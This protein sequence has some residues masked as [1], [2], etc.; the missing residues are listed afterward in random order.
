MPEHESDLLDIDEFQHNADW[1]KA[2]PDSSAALL[3]A[4]A[5]ERPRMRTSQEREDYA[6][7]AMLW[8]EEQHPRDADGQFS[9]KPEEKKLSQEEILAETRRTKFK[10][11]GQGEWEWDG[12]S[13]EAEHGEYGP[14]GWRVKRLSD[15]EMGTLKGYSDGW[16]IYLDKDKGKTKPSKW[17]ARHTVPDERL[18]KGT[19]NPLTAALDKKKLGEQQTRGYT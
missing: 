8:K 9:E 5:A 16:S 12:V 7:Q 11:R 14:K 19:K 2:T 1:P 10:V 6:K 13:P 18:T 4:A 17:D 15:G 3:A